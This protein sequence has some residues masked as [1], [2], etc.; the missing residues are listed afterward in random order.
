M[1][2]AFHAIA[3]LLRAVR[4]AFNGDRCALCSLRRS[5]RSIGGQLGPSGRVLCEIRVFYTRTVCGRDRSIVKTKSDLRSTENVRSRKR[6]LAIEAQVIEAN[7]VRIERP[8]AIHL[9]LFD[10]IGITA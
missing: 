5:H 1:E 10:P 4:D 2:I 7:L 8:H 9:D 6:D 3:E